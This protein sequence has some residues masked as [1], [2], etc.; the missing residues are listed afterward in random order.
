MFRMSAGEGRIE[1][2]SRTIELPIPIS[3]WEPLSTTTHFIPHTLDTL[4]KATHF[5]PI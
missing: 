5:I 2:R 3:I 4:S 1:T